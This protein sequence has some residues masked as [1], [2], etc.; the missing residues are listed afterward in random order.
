[1]Y[2]PSHGGP[3]HSPG[4]RRPCCNFWYGKK[5]GNAAA[6]WFVRNHPLPSVLLRSLHQHSTSVSETRS[7]VSNSCYVKVNVRSSN[8]VIAAVSQVDMKP[9]L[10]SKGNCWRTLAMA[11]PTRHVTLQVESMANQSETFN[12]PTGHHR[13]LNGR[14]RP[15][16]LKEIGGHLHCLGPSSRHRSLRRTRHFC[17]FILCLST[18][19]SP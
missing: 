11:V 18:R 1:M 16:P 14:L 6:K 13:K 12:V 8:C 7:L 17:A 10:F 19:I 5:A 2:S 15:V 3:T 4:W 9:L